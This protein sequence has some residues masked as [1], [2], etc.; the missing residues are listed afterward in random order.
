MRHPGSHRRLPRETQQR[1][2]AHAR[3]GHRPAD[4]GRLGMSRSQLLPPPP[5]L[6]PHVPL[7]PRDIGI[8]IGGNLSRTTLRRAGLINAARARSRPA[9]P[10]IQPTYRARTEQRPVANRARALSSLKCTGSRT[11]SW[12]RRRP[13]GRPAGRSGAWRQR[14]GCTWLAIFLGC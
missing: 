13:P 6:R 8:P 2:R 10:P 5:A 9:V 14:S 12:T 11:A 4:L 3:I 1:S 7:G